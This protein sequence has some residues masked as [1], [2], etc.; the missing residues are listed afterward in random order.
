MSRPIVLLLIVRGFRSVPRAREQI[1]P[2]G[3]LVL[4]TPL[5]ES[6]TPPAW[7]APMAVDA[8]AQRSQQGL[9]PPCARC[10]PVVGAMQRD[11][12]AI[13]LR[14]RFYL[15]GIESQSRRPLA[16]ASLLGGAASPSNRACSADVVACG[17]LPIR[18]ALARRGAPSLPGSRRLLVHFSAV[19]ERSDRCDQLRRCAF[20]ACANATDQIRSDAFAPR[21]DELRLGERLHRGSRRVRA[22]AQ[23]LGA[24][25]SLRSASRR[26]ARALRS[27]RHRLTLHEPIGGVRLRTIARVARVD[28]RESLRDVVAL[29]PLTREALPSPEERASADGQR[30]L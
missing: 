7:L 4:V 24:R 3:R 8:G 14:E 26:L 20:A 11:E 2:L 6:N 25:R 19:S 30:S 16:R 22:V 1:G 9:P 29:V 12:C 13:C 5:V 15:R 27:A 23:P 10:N 17:N 28:D 18:R 21:R